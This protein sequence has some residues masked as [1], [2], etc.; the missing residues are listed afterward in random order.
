MFADQLI[1][2]VFF[3]NQLPTKKIGCFFILKNSGIL[4]DF[5]K[6]LNIGS[7]VKV[8]AGLWI[9]LVISRNQLSLM[10]IT[11]YPCINTKKGGTFVFFN[12]L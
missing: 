5:Y 4:T 2:G 9:G 10:T 11:Y 12:F 8:A 7:G 6:L 1:R 3:R